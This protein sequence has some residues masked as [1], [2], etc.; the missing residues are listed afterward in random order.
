MYQVAILPLIFISQL[1]SLGKIS[2]ENT[3]IEAVS[4]NPLVII[5]VLLITG[6]YKIG[7]LVKDEATPGKKWRKIKVVQRDGK[8]ID[9]L[10]SSIREIS[11]IIYLIPLLGSL[12]YLISVIL[13]L[14]SKSR[15]AIHD[16]VGGTI[17]IKS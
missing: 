16:Y 6:L 12:L 8:R 14:F 7:Y 15:K 10:H 1:I 4:G 5:L 13:V 11:Q 3:D 17:V 2:L 9:L